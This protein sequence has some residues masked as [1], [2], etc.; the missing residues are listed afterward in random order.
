MKSV[1][2]AQGKGQRFA[3]FAIDT[4]DDVLLI[5]LY[6]KATDFFILSVDMLKLEEKPQNKASGGVAHVVN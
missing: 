6:N 2:R 4:G 1:Q 3:V 5:E